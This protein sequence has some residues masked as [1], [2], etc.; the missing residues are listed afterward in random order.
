MVNPFLNILYFLSR[1]KQLNC[2][3]KPQPLTY[4][5]AYSIRNSSIEE[6]NWIQTYLPLLTFVMI[7]QFCF[8]TMFFLRIYKQFSAMIDLLMYC[9][10]DMVKFVSLLIIWL[11]LYNIFL[12]SL[13]AHINV[14]SSDEE[15]LY[16]PEVICHMINNWEAIIGRQKPSLYI[17]WG[18]KHQK[19]FS[20]QFY[21][22][23]IWSIYILNDI[24][25]ITI[26]VNFL[27]AGMQQT[28]EKY[29]SQ[30]N[31]IQLIKQSELNIECK[32]TRHTLGS[33]Q[34]F[35]FIV[36]FSATEKTVK[37]VEGG[38]QFKDQGLSNMITERVA[39]NFHSMQEYVQKDLREMQMRIDSVEQSNQSLHQQ[40]NNQGNQLAVI[41]QSLNQIINYQQSL[42][43]GTLSSPAV[44]LAPLGKKMQSA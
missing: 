28:Y 26:F 22:I 7:I 38:L 37:D 44:N 39:R 10:K 36:I 16:M 29:L 8:R 12:T 1:L 41:Q 20:S 5:N 35:D 19:S 13:G 27:I 40:L 18:E 42:Y 25:V 34:S 17:I 6:L 30:I 23:L 4:K 2:T 31:N 21:E 11:F 24:F 33:L 3:H 14:E 43:D 15:C 9:I 32:L